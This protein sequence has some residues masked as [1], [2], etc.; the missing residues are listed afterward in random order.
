MRYFLY[1]RHDVLQNVRTYK[2]FSDTR[3]FSGSLVREITAACAS[4]DPDH[5]ILPFLGLFYLYVPLSNNLWAFAK[6]TVEERGDYF[7][8]ILHGVVLDE[9]ERAALG[10]NPFLLTD[11]LEPAVG[12]HRALDLLQ[13]EVPYFGADAQ[14]ARLLSMMEHLGRTPRALSHAYLLGEMTTQ[15]LDGRHDLNFGY[16]R[17]L[18]A[19][20]WGWLYHCLPVESRKR[21]SLA[22]FSPFW[23]PLANLSGYPPGDER[24]QVG[25]GG[26]AVSEF[27][28]YFAELIRAEPDQINGFLQRLEAMTAD[29]E[30]LKSDPRHLA[31]GTPIDYGKY[32]HAVSVGWQEITINAA[33]AWRA[34]T[35]GRALYPVKAEALKRVWQAHRIDADTVFPHL[36]LDILQTLKNDWKRLH[37]EGGPPSVLKPVKRIFD[38]VVQFTD[39]V[40]HGAS[41]LMLLED[42]HT[43]PTYFEK[44][45]DQT[46]IKAVFAEKPNPR[47][48][49]SLIRSVLRHRGSWNPHLELLYSFPGFSEMDPV[50]H[51]QIFESLDSKQRRTLVQQLWQGG[52][53][54]DP[55][56]FTTFYQSLPKAEQQLPVFLETMRPLFIK[57]SGIALVP[58]LKNT[59]AMDPE[60]GFTALSFWI[61]K[62]NA[63]EILETLSQDPEWCRTLAPHWWARVENERQEL[64]VCWAWKRTFPATQTR[65]WE[66]TPFQESIRNK[67]HFAILFDAS[68]GMGS[69]LFE[70]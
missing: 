27:G 40:A 54:T 37:T 46:F 10:Y 70:D 58:L 22:G 56:R 61:R 26:A 39:A 5:N 51:A 8:Y 47:R 34:V 68:K 67:Q 53:R 16:H 24:I 23:R 14:K 17:D 52:Y 15:I 44:I 28:R 57:K 45:D 64:L 31:A 21:L 49:A 63:A 30:N 7:S 55:N 2:I 11:R 36:R 65:I 18:G 29:Y 25:A 20:F 42:P 3:H 32:L 48:L 50:L 66:N 60:K 12:N 62:N 33:N 19:A 4:G 43:A 35:T 41:L 9:R 59:V 69:V 1:G 6:G 38:D 13:E